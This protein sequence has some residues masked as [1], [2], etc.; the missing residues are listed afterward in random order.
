MASSRPAGLNPPISHFLHPV[1]HVLHVLTERLKLC[2]GMQSSPSWCL[3]SAGGRESTHEQGVTQNL[4]ELSNVIP[5]MGLVISPERIKT[6]GETCRDWCLSGA[7]KVM[8]IKK[9]EGNALPAGVITRVKAQ[10]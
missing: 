9:A 6:F 7:G 4:Q 2:L 8:E 1:H 3:R 5:T 10:G